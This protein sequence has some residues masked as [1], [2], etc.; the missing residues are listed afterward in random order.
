MVNPTGSLVRQV[1][2]ISRQAAYL[3]L[4]TIKIVILRLS[5]YFVSLKLALFL[6]GFY[7]KPRRPVH[8]FGDT[9]L[10][11][12]WSMTAHGKVR[13]GLCCHPWG[14]GASILA[15][16]ENQADLWRAASLGITNNQ[17]DHKTKLL[18]NNPLLVHTQTHIKSGVSLSKMFFILMFT[19]SLQKGTFLNQDK[20]SRKNST[21]YTT[22]DHVPVSE[23]DG[24]RIPKWNKLVSSITKK[25]K[26]SLQSVS[27]LDPIFKQPTVTNCYSSNNLSC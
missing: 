8:N 10:N 2:P 7:S 22:C 11:T 17:N 3:A 25:E 14:R 15:K 12:G 27:S 26:R 1:L 6:L 16:P 5:A 13:Y 23:L 21:Y 24:K 20:V 4:P 18:Q 19:V 9:L